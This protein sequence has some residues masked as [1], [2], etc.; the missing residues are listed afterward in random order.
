MIIVIL[1]MMSNDDNKDDIAD[2][3]DDG[4]KL[5]VQKINVSIKI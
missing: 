2:V 1:M 5:L 4:N 3:S